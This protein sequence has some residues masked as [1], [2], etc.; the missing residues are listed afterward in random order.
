MAI[1]R[2]ARPGTELRVDEQ[3][4]APA[5]LRGV[6]VPWESLSVVLWSDHK[7]GKPVRERFTR[8]AF[9]EVLARGDLDVVAVYEH[10]DGRSLLGRTKSGTLR[11]QETERGLE[12]D[13]DLPDTSG[14]RDLREWIARR[15]VQGSSFAFTPARGGEQ[16]EETETE[17]LR[18]ISKVSGLFDVSPV[19]HPAYPGSDVGLRGDSDATE[20]RSSLEAWRSKGVEVVAAR[21]RELELVEL[22]A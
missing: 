15:D 4:G 7:T 22:D 10:G 13:V 21:E 14:A 8:G 19:V 11:I 17:V 20:A 2:R 18:T 6:A 9:A 1:E 5:T 12:Y 16:W 3:E